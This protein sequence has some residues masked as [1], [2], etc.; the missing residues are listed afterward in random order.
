VYIV[1]K[2]SNEEWIIDTFLL[3]CRIIGR[4][5]EETMLSQIIEKAKSL[6]VKRIKGEFISTSKNKPAENFYNN[7]GFKKI[8]DYWIFDTNQKIETSDHIKLRRN[9]E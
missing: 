1:K 9:D 5:V 6:G 8:G 2:E 4:G 7:Y 3:S